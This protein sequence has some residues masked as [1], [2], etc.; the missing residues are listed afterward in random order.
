MGCGV[1]VLDDSCLLCHRQ[2]IL[3]KAGQAGRLPPRSSEF[4]QNE[5]SKRNS[6]VSD[7]GEVG[8]VRED[9]SKL[10]KF[11]EPL[12]GKLTWPEGFQ[13]TSWDRRKD[14]QGKMSAGSVQQWQDYRKDAILAPE[15]KKPQADPD[16][17]TQTYNPHRVLPFKIN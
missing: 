8:D 9:A 6:A 10:T 5:T 2:M 12:S 15:T 13:E 3:H 11:L 7:R 17:S 1:G 4:R 16:Q 14:S